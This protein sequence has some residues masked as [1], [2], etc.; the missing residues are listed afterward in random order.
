MPVQLGLRLGLV[1]SQLQS[2]GLNQVRVDNK[3]ITSELLSGTANQ[4]LMPRMEEN[5][6]FEITQL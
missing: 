5:K 2:G 1:S 3:E 4:I 6:I